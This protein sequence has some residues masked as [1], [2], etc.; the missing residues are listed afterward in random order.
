MSNKLYTNT[1]FKIVDPN[2]M[3][4]LKRTTKELMSLRR[5][6]YFEVYF[7]PLIKLN[8]TSGCV[9]KQLMEF[10]SN[11][12]V[13]CGKSVLAGNGF[14]KSIAFGLPVNVKAFHTN[15]HLNARLLFK[16]V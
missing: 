14:K 5:S 6:V 10:K 4:Q 3:K 13:R 7:T 2:V 9:S 15:C 16:N 12:E 11:T 1:V 8:S